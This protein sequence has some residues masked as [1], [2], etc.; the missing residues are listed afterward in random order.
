MPEDGDDDDFDFFVLHKSRKPINNNI[1]SK[2][3]TIFY[4][5]EN[6]DINL[7]LALSISTTS[8]RRKTGGTTRQPEVTSESL[9][10]IQ[11]AAQQIILGWQSSR[12]PAIVLESSCRCTLWNLAKS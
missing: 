12:Y 9:V 2:V 1:P 4:H 10:E 5:P 6:Q 7:A 3:Q 8:K 11:A